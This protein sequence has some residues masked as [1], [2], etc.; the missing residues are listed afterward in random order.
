MRVQ[1]AGCEDGRGVDAYGD[2][3]IST[4]SLPAHVLW[5]EQI[6][7]TCSSQNI[8]PHPD[9]LNPQG[10][11]ADIQKMAMIKVDQMLRDK[12]M[13]ARVLMTVHDELL[14]EVRSIGGNTDEVRAVKHLLK[15]GMSTAA[16]KHMPDVKLEVKVFAGDNW[17]QISEKKGRSSK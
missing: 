1:G 13:D 17:M 9:F 15:E 8:Q 7:G 10:S 3:Y 12:N 2:A 16:G 5:R 4:A 11:A 6:F 14:L